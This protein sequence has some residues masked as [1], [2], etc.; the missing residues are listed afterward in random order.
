MDSLEVLVVP[1][2]KVWATYYRTAT[3]QAVSFGGAQANGTL[4]GGSSYA[5]TDGR[6]YP[7]GAMTRSGTLSASFNASTGTF[8]GSATYGSEVLAFTT[9]RAS[10]SLYNYAT[11]STVPMLQ[12][13]GGA[14]KGDS[15]YG[16][17]TMTI[18]SP[19]CTCDFAGTAT[20][21]GG[22]GCTFKG[23]LLLS[24]VNAFAVSEFNLDSTNPQVCRDVLPASAVGL[25]YTYAPGG[26]ARLVVATQSADRSKGLNFVLVR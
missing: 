9:T 14:W 11:A 24:T 19:A 20:I 13:I 23:K 7:Y 4:T 2:D 10:T 17:I 3:G 5:A 15:Q 25:M 16:P 21:S 26:T 18:S 1:G 8:N 22:V 12:A 6:D